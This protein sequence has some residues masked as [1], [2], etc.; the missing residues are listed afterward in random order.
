MKEENNAKT[1]ARFLRWPW[2]IVIYLLLVAALRIFAIPVILILMRLQQ[3]NNPHGIAE[4]YCLSRT[5]KR[6]SWLLWSLLTFLISVC[7][8]VFFYV[9]MQQEKSYWE[10]MDYI[11][12]AIAG[13]GAALMLIAGIYM[14]FVAIRDTFFPA[15]SELAQSIRNQLPFPDGAPPVNE[16]FAMVDN[17]L[18]ENGHWFGP[19][20]IGK[21]WVLGES[22]N[23]IDRLRGIFI[24]DEIH[25]H[26]T[27]TGTRTSRTL[28]LALIDN[29][30]KKS[31]TDFRSPDDLKA[32]ADFLSLRVPDAV[33]G[34]NGQCSKFWTMDEIEQEAFEREFRH[35]QSL[36]EAEHAWQETSNG[37]SQEVIL[38]Q[39][40]GSMTSRVTFSLVKEQLNHC[41]MDDSLSFTLSLSHPIEKSGRTY[42][43]LNCYG[44]QQA[45]NQ[46]TG[47]ML[48][49]TL[50]FTSTQDSAKLAMTQYMDARQ[51]EKVLENWLIQ[52][53]PDLT[54]WF[55]GQPRTASHSA[56]RA[57]SHAS[58]GFLGLIMA[59]GA[60]ESHTT[61][62]KEDVQASAEGI[63][64]GTYQ[65][66]EH[67]LPQRNLWIRVKAGDKSDG[68]CTVEASRP[69]IPQCYFS[70]KMSARQAASWLTGYPHG[71]FLPNGKDWKKYTV[72]NTGKNTK[73]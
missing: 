40:D 24:I 46:G 62:T 43:A 63:I 28:Q 35:K 10:Y 27:Q 29:R 15:K 54:G 32:A 39:T 1:V 6:L 18:K 30:W 59:S 64:D 25:Q 23:R 21:E 52:Q 65:T 31:V 72:K 33:R 17:D 4:G 36:R 26:S 20:G 37:I 11:K 56:P 2:N 8:G 55:L 49:L 42:R 22:A 9:E 5:R 38:R 70:A 44:G 48:L 67:I 3:K 51:A 61:F 69:D 19:V 47:E 57:V 73:E 53:L 7:L 71:Q 66:V 16:L 41:L 58:S 12:L 13:G 60:C 14:A 45:R 68:R 50:D 34:K